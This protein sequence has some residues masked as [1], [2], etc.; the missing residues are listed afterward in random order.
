MYVLINFWSVQRSIV[1]G[2]VQPKALLWCYRITQ[3]FCESDM[4][5]STHIV[6]RVSPR[7]WIHTARTTHM[8]LFKLKVK[9]NVTSHHIISYAL[10]A[11]PCSASEGGK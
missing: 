7:L 5:L 10:F 3:L 4:I 9:P 8:H 1:L 6:L 11:A 2:D